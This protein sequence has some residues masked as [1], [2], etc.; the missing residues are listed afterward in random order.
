[1]ASTWSTRGGG[2]E[3]RCQEAS[4]NTWQNHTC[5][6]SRVRHGCLAPTRRVMFWPPPA[7]RGDRRNQNAGSPGEVCS[8]RTGDISGSWPSGTP[9]AR[10]PEGETRAPDTLV[11]VTVTRS[12]TRV[13]F[14]PSPL[15]QLERQ[16]RTY[17][18]IPL[19][20]SGICCD[21]GDIVCGRFR[22]IVGDRVAGES[23]IGALRQ[24][25][26]SRRVQAA[27]GSGAT[28]GV[29]EVSGRFL[30]AS[31]R[32]GPVPVPGAPWPRSRRD[33]LN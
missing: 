17:L 12:R 1:M 7:G 8:R 31:E 32:A 3:P 23:P 30:E 26:A 21:K 22:R 27:S 4:Q 16:S 29:R 9:P 25:Q 2:C 33:A 11:D 6:L 5:G 14:P 20:S 19:I 13:R 28:T 10:R 15:L 24:S 18:Q